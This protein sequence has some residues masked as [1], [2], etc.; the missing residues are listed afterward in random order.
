M[1]IQCQYDLPVMEALSDLVDWKST[2]TAPGELSVM[3]VSTTMMPQLHATCSD[4]GIDRISLHLQSITVYQLCE[5]LS[6][7]LGS[8]ATVTHL[9]SQRTY[10]RLELG[11]IT[12]FLFLGLAYRQ[13]YANST[14][15]K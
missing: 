13:N 8:W 12:C 1:C 11:G 3:T 15:A 10:R 5:M 6:V 4:L 9:E 7:G 2:T 14:Y